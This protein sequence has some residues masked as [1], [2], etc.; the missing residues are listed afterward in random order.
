[1]SKGQTKVAILL[2]SGE[3]LNNLEPKREATLLDT[4][5]ID[6]P[7]QELMAGEG[8]KQNLIAKCKE[9]GYETEIN[10]SVLVNK[11]YDCDLA[12]T[13]VPVKKRMMAGKPVTRGG[14][15]IGAMVNGK[16]T[17]ATVRRQNA[18]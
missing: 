17:M 16:K 4:F 12:I 3:K 1:M 9:Y 2:G 6:K 5:V 11:E 15:P 10:P 8:W 13:V 18:K 7:L 14:K